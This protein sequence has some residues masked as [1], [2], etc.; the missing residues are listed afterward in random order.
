MPSI[1]AMSSVKANGVT[2]P[3]HLA[4][5]LRGKLQPPN[6]VKPSFAGRTVIITG[7]NTGVGFEASV[8]FVKLGAERVIIGVR[9]LEKGEKAKERIEQRADRK[10]VVEVWQLDMLDYDSVK[11]F[12]KRAEE[13]LDQLDIAILN[14]GVV[15]ATHQQSKYGWEKSLQT[16]VISTTLL[17]LMLMPKL[18]SS[19]TADFTPVLQLVSSGNHYLVQ[20]LGWDSSDTQG[21]LARQNQASNF[22]LQEQCTVSKLFLEYAHAGLTQLANSSE[23]PGK[24][25]VY[26]V[27]VCP[28]A[29]KSELA[30][31]SNAWY[32]RAGLFV[33][34]SIFMKSTEEG[35][36]IYVS[37]AAL[38]ERGHGRFWQDDKL[39]A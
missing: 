17:A 20:D 18:K 24:P 15:A 14:A 26:V 1:T 25:K 11:A 10:G 38:G 39:K 28:G 16:N 37:G 13:E 23:S 3:G 32:M 22:G 31:D 36:R 2:S 30:R 29:T 4:W 33:F 8:K 5:M 34:G 9:S 19:K 7:A 12:A 6:D 27:S 21:P 35:A